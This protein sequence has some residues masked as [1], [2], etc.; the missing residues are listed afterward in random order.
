MRT[1]L[2]QGSFSNPKWQ[3]YFEVDFRQPA[4]QQASVILE[5]ANISKATS[6]LALGKTNIGKKQINTSGKEMRWQLS[7]EKKR[8]S[9]MAGDA[10]CAEPAWN[11]I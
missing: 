2:C 4:R 1:L 9:H 6:R 11:L 7:R 8:N 5:L 3:H 10:H